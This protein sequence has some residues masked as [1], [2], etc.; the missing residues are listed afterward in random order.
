MILKKMKLKSKNIS[1]TLNPALKIYR[2]KLNMKIME[3]ETIILK[4]KITIFQDL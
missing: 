2:R 4:Q 1:R 3:E